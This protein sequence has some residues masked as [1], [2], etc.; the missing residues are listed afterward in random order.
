MDHNQ[1]EK[2]CVRS[3]FFGRVTLAQCIVQ[4]A[5]REV[6]RHLQAVVRAK[7]FY[8]ST[9]SE[10]ITSHLDPADMVGLHRASKESK[11]VVE[12]RFVNSLLIIRRASMP[13]IIPAEGMFNDSNFGHL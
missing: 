4:I 3:A 2:R 9:I 7:R 1:D 5:H 10:C 12:N 8:S 13:L 6:A 11:Q